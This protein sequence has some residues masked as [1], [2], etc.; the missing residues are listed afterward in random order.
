MPARSLDPRARRALLPAT[1][2]ALVLLGAARFALGSTAW[3]LVLDALLALAAA[4]GTL[5]AARRARAG[6]SRT[7]WHCVTSAVLL[8]LLAPL[9][10]LTGLPDAV[11]NAGRLG[12][13]VMTGAAWWLTSLAPWTW[14]RVRLTVD[15]AIAG[16]ALFVVAWSPLLQDTFAEASDDVAGIAAV[17]L[18]L[19]AVAA[20]TLVGGVSVTEIPR[21]RRAMPRVM[22][23]ALALVAVSDVLWVRAG[24]PLWAVAF[25]AILLATRVYRGTSA[26][27][28]VRSVRPA[29]VFAPYVVLAPAI[30]TVAVQYARGDVP[31]A[32]VKAVAA[33]GLLL[34][35]RQHSTLAENQLLVG[36]LEETERQLRHRAMHDSLTGLGGRA[37][38]HERLDAAVRAYQESGNP[39]AVVFIDLD[40]FKQINDAHGHAA[41]DNVLVAIARRLGH[42]LAPFGD[43]AVAFRMSGDEF[44]VLLTG[45]AAVGAC[46]TARGLLGA[47]SAPIEV[48]DAS[49]A[50]TGSVGVAEPGPDVPAEPSALLRAADVAMYG[51]KHG[52]KGGV[53]QA[54]GEVRES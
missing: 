34:V 27:N 25:A 45:E 36:R 30:A 8:W 19:A 1:L 48:D 22:M 24:R 38:L 20:L 49:V 12:F 21:Q 10:W 42:A 9:A 35:I 29:L 32:E 23:L 4:T 26:R 7:A 14:T 5:E 37:L 52:G 33:V 40:D 54:Q 43:G 2:G 11:A 44:A 18:P 3:G 16:G 50:V 17:A 46:T 28:A 51:V 31:P 47:I 41:G 53:A 39:V 15:A 6:R 13:V